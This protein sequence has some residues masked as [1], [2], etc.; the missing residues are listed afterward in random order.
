MATTI[1]AD[2]TNGLILTADTSGIIEIQADGT[3]VLKVT[4]ANGALEIPAGTTAQRPSTPAT[5]AF[6]YNTTLSYTE[7]YNGSAWENVNSGL[8]SS[9]IGVTVQ[10]YDADTAKYDDTTANFTGTLQNGGSNVVVDS[11]IGSTVQAYDATIVVDADIGVSVQA[12][13]ADTAKYDDVTANFTGTLQNG[14]SNVVVD[15]DI[16]STVQAYDADL[17]TLGGLSSADGNFIVGSAT[18]WVV[19]SGATARTSLGLGTAATSATGDFATAAQG[20]LA[21]S[22]L[23]S[24]DIGSTVQAYDADTTKNDVANT[25]TANQTINANLIVDTNTLYVDATGNRVGIGNAATD[26]TGT[27]LDQLVVGSGSGNQGMIIDSGAG[28]QSR[29][30]F[31]EAGTIKGGIQYD[32]TG[33]SIDFYVEGI[34]TPVADISSSGTVTATTFSGALSGNATTATTLQTGRTI[35]LTGDVTGTSG[36]FDGGANLSFATNIASNVVGAGELNVTGNGTTAQFLRSDGDGSFTWAE[37]SGGGKILQVVQATDTVARTASQVNNTWYNYSQINASITP[38]STSSKI[39]I[40]VMLGRFRCNSN[41]TC[42]TIRRSTTDILVGDAAGSRPRATMSHTVGGEDN[43][44]ASGTFLT[45]IDSPSTTSSTEYRLYY[46]G[47]QG[48][49]Y[50]NRNVTY[51]NSFV[52]YNANAA[53]TMILME[54]GA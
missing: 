24:A 8:Q 10:G 30:G 20:S 38:S 18:G 47:E 35:S 49:F 36:T 27:T 26:I 41:N 22:A 32:G 52:S 40:F 53:S 45:A 43:N 17:T 34:V 44:H 5:G 1:N 28:G 12:Y 9:D 23:Q 21:D 29:Y 6:R 48:T 2:T 15:S 14:G 37:P 13:D 50:I 19:E 7:I 46:M 3:A 11:D 4:G 25:F 16:G 39:L 33:N 54:I 51:T 31:S 42:F